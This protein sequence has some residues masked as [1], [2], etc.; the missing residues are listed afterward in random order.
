M[1]EQTEYIYKLLNGYDEVKLGFSKLYIL[2][3]SFDYACFKNEELALLLSKIALSRK[4]NCNPLALINIVAQ[5]GVVATV[6]TVRSAALWDEVI[7]K[8]FNF[9]FYEV[10]TLEEFD[11]E[12]EYMQSLFSSKTEAEETGLSFILKSMTANQK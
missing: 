9:L 6:D 3:N 1:Q 10:N 4:V 2:V 5:V 12:K 8:N 11:K 7:L